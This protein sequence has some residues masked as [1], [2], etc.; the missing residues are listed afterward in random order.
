ME[1]GEISA[2]IAVESVEGKLLRV[3]KWLETRPYAVHAKKNTEEG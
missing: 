2:S 3:T 1:E